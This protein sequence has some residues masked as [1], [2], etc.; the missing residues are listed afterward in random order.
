MLT[1]I[2]YFSI[3]V[4]LYVMHFRS[5]FSV[6]LFYILGGGQ[7]TLLCFLA[8]K[9]VSGLNPIG[10]MIH[11]LDKYDVHDVSL[12]APLNGRLIMSAILSLLGFSIL[13]TLHF[14]LVG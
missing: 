7:G 11:S 9:A 14:C 4:T 10:K 3:N 12:V 13:D 1:I 5:V 8:G 6:S 2:A